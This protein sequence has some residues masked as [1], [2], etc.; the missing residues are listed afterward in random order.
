MSVDEQRMIN[1]AVAY[2]LAGERCE[3]AF[4]FGRYPTHRIGAPTITCYA[5][6]VEIALK[7]LLRLTLN[8]NNI[9]PRKLKNHDLKKLYDEIPCN[10]KIYI[11]CFED[12]FSK[13]EI[14][15]LEVDSEGYFIDRG[16][17]VTKITV[18]KYHPFVD[19]RYPYEHEFLTGDS[20]NL[21]RCFIQAHAEIRRI[22]PEL[23]SCY[24]RD[25]GNFD[26]D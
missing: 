17:V 8:L 22:C 18:E 21:R 9:E 25:W 16:M 11:S 23:I 1:T 14:N 3:P 19:W 6:A 12:L 26:P 20:D 2:F 13:L 4:G 15:N 7:L 24:E 5:M 10:N